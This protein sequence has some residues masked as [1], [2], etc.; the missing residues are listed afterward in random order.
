M[1]AG[2]TRH[3]K[4]NI[5]QE[6]TLMVALV[7]QVKTGKYPEYELCG[8]IGDERVIVTGPQQALDRQ[9]EKLGVK[10]ADAKGRAFRLERAPNKEDAKKSW[11]NL[12]P[13]TEADAQ[14]K[15]PSTPPAHVAG[16]AVGDL[17]GDPASDWDD[18]PK[19]ANGQPEGIT[20]QTH[21]PREVAYFALALR[22][23]AFQAEVGK[24]HQC[25]FD[26]QSVN[27][28]TFSI[29]GGAR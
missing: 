16:P 23:A 25:P 9:W 13:A 20:G 17:P 27:A 12:Y 28:M 19:A 24:Q 6:V 4:L 21:S 22:V 8:Y 10:P 18:A 29:M 2:T 15:A 5:G 1:A 26:L 14:P 11:W 3:I 7:R